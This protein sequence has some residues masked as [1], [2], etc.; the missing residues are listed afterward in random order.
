M[1]HNS[2]ADRASFI[3][4]AMLT[5]GALT[6]GE[7]SPQDSMFSEAEAYERF[8]GRWSRAIAPLLVRFAGVQS[9]DRVLDIGSGTGALAAA[10]AA[11]AP[12]ARITGIDPSAAYVG[13]AR[14][15]QGTD[16][17][18]FEEGD[19]QQMRF[20][21]ASFD[22]TLS[23]LVVNFIPD[24]A[25][26]VREMRR[27]T[28]PGG[29]VAAAVWDYADGMEMLRVF[30]DAAVALRPGDDKKDERHMPFSRR[31]ELGALWRAQ[32]LSDVVEEPLTIETRF[33]SFDDYWG[34]F[35]QKQGPAGA[36]VAALPAS[37]QEAL[38]ARLR[39]RLLPGAADGPIV[40]RARAWA[41][42]GVV[43]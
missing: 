37:E 30:W 42:R 34:P 17:V 5:A 25:K 38:R 18:S 40:L 19:A 26:A 31:G 20:A 23:L 10:L 33:T 36:Y 6:V 2:S 11:E 12:G 1:Q 13:F 43:R 15:R 14:A 28:R 21:D 7:G 27:V 41:V 39:Q 35:T 16:S 3:A 8:M 32:G 22:R 29:I 4:I 24:P 9:S